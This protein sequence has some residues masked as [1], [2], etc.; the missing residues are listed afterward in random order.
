MTEYTVKS[1]KKWQNLGH[2]G[3]KISDLGTN[4]HQK[5]LKRRLLRATAVS[6]KES[7]H[8]K[9]I[10]RSLFVLQNMAFFG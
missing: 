8:E 9:Y 3:K 6:A 1:A 7:G 2:W 4:T 10:Q 5:K